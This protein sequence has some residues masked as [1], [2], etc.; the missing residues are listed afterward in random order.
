MGILSAKVDATFS[1]K[2]SRIIEAEKSKGGLV[3]VIK[4]EL[5]RGCLNVFDV[6][7][8]VILYFLIMEKVE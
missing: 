2:F 1:R 4:M 8:T 6:Q 5:V 7:L 3:L